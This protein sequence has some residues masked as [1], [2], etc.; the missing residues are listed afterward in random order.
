MGRLSHSEGGWENENV[1]A[2]ADGKAWKNDS[3]TA[4]RLKIEDI[5][6]LK[7]SW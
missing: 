2:A 4:N 5:Q 6:N 7:E 1:K 3:I